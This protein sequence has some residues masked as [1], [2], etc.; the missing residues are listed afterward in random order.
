[1][2]HHGVVV[3]ALFWW[4]Q[5]PG[6][7]QLRF[8]CEM[9]PVLA[10]QPRILENWRDHGTKTNQRRL[11]HVVLWTRHHVRTTLCCHV[12]MIRKG[13]FCRGQMRKSL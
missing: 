6:T 7:P 1:M 2:L 9:N 12:L 4:S 13:H 11:L 10:E 3:S 5:L 8:F